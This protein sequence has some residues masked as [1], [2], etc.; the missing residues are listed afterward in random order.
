MNT[1]TY[2]LIKNGSLGIYM[3]GNSIF[4]LEANTLIKFNTFIDQYSKGIQN[5]HQAFTIIEGNTF[6]TTSPYPG[7]AAIYLDRSYRVHKIIK[8]KILGVPGTGMYFVDCTAQ[9]GVHGIIANNFIQ[10]NDSAGI[11]MVNGSYQD[12]VYNSILM[13]GTTPS[14]SALLMRGVGQ[15]KIVKNNILANTGG[16]FSYVVSDSAVYGIQASDH[17]NLYATG[18]YV[19]NYN[20]TNITSLNNWIIKSHKDSSS[21]K[22]N[23]SFVSVGNLHVASIAMDDRGMPINNVNDDIDGQTRSSVTPDIGADEYTSISRTVGVTAI[24]SPVDSTCGSTA[25]T[26]KVVVSN[27]GGNPESGFNVVTKISGALV[28]TL[29]INHSA[30]LAPGQSDTITY[31]STINTSLGGV[32]NFQSYT[33]LAVDDVHANDTLEFPFH[34]FAPPVSP[35]VTP[36][37]I[38]GP[39]TDTLN[40][41]SSDTLRWYSVAN[42]GPRVPVA[43]T[44]LPVPSVNLGSDVNVNQGNSTV[45]NAGPGFTSYLWSPGNLTTQTINVNTQ[46]C[47]IVK[48]TNSSGCD[49]SD[50]VCVNII[51][52]FDVGVTAIG[53]PIDQ[54]CADDSIQVLIHVSNLGANTATG[55]PVV[56][57]ITGAVTQTFNDTINANITAGTDVVLNMGTINVSAGGVIH[58]TA[59]TAYSNDNDL[60]NDTLRV[61]DT[62]VVAPALPSAINATRC[63]P[64]IV[65]LISSASD[66]VY[67]YDAPVGGNLLFTGENY[68]IP[69]LSASTTVYTQNGQQCN[70]QLRRVVTATINPLPN[71]YL[72]ADTTAADSLVLNAGA[73]FVTYEWSTSSTAQTITVFQTNSYSVCVT[74]NNGCKNCDTIS[75]GIFVGVEQLNADNRIRLFPNPSHSSITLE[76]IK[77]INGPVSL[78]ISNMEGQIIMNEEHDNMATGFNRT[79]DVSYFAKGVYLLKIKS[80]TGSAVYRLIVQ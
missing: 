3:N 53:S 50:T 69:V 7:Y 48:V 45:L 58:I 39:G 26:V 34:L 30:V 22:L 57:N 4:S 15:G 8:N 6:S 44:V 40:A 18:T 54:D 25:T 32:F 77:G 24:I 49:A 71:I 13:T 12:V 63:G 38:C 28:T 70:N 2:N 59:Y 17:N 31:S 65:V 10:S 60:T 64:G 73:G 23:P 52:P 67:W 62:I 68:V 80:D 1:I 55:I 78:A 72:G 5:T 29:T 41:S 75:I 35:S 79:W 61:N 37:S 43:L 19:G 21:V 46:G 14:F 51:V 11:S 76:M 74:N 9:A 56:V 20:D 47:Y 27:T 16:G 36:T 42:E 66:S 33:S